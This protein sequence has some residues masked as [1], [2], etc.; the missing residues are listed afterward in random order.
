VTDNTKII[1]VIS[2]LSRMRERVRV[3]VRVR[4]RVIQERIST[5]DI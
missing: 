5:E 2:S 4:A 1:T 3:R